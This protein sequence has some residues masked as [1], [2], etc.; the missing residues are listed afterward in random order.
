MSDPINH[1]EHY[2]S[3]P[4]GVECITVTEHFGFNVGN[5]I[6]YLWRAGLKGDAL[7]D[8]RKA[9]WYV[10]REIE[11]REIERRTRPAGPACTCA[12]VDV[13]TITDEPGARRTMPDERDPDCP[14]HGDTAAQ[15]AEVRNSHNTGQRCPLYVNPSLPA[16]R[17][18]CVESS[19]GEL[20]GDVREALGVEHRCTRPAGHRVTATP[21]K[22]WEEARANAHT[23]GDLWWWPWPED[24]R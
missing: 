7:A 5:A 11:R 21:G 20:C 18:T 19:A 4:S 16:E 22:D 6:K 14:L 2:T 9:A 17:C 1:P 8:L 23:D 12:V 10:Q 3:H 15:R 13:T 24:E